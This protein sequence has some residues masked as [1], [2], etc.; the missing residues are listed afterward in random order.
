MTSSR[1]RILTRLVRSAAATAI[2]G[3]V[4]F[5]SGPDVAEIVPAPYNALL[6]AVLLPLFMAADKWLRERDLPVSI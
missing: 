1:K 6:S 5:L 3:A 2:A 4:G